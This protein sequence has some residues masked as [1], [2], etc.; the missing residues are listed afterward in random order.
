MADAFED[1][2]IGLPDDQKADFFR[3]LRESDVSQ[4]DT[5][6]AKILRALQMYKTYYETIPESI[7][8]TVSEIKKL[9]TQAAQSGEAG[10]TSLNQLLQY[11]GQ[12][13]EAL[14]KIHLHVEEAATKAS[15]AV[16]K[17]MTDAKDKINAQIEKT[18]TDASAI[19]TTQMSA[20]MEKAIPLSTIQE[21]G[22]VFSNAIATGKQATEELKSNLKIMRR[23]HLWSFAVA[24]FCLVAIFC[25][26]AHFWYK[27]RFEKHCA[28]VISQAAHNQDVLLEL[29][30]S[31]RKLE[32]AVDANGAKLL[33]MKNA[34]GWS[35]LNNSGVIEYK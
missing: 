24:A 20:A 10:E 30:L 25:I 34:K 26:S 17:R 19:V 12:V 8:K 27:D 18:A 28:L 14:K 1:L 16:S 32:V 11:T 29:A 21:A 4:H 9:T 7:Q 6:L 22:N 13:N 35:S 31:K 33:V 23:V 5:E 3:I 15:D 2:A